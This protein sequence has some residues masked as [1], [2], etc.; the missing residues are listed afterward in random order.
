MNTLRASATAKSRHSANVDNSARSGLLHAQL[1]APGR[2]G[3][4]QPGL[5]GSPNDSDF[6]ALQCAL[7][8]SGGL[9]RGQDLA[10]SLQDRQAGDFTSLARWIVTRR[11]FSFAWHDSFWVPM[12]QLDP[13][14]ASLRPGAQSVVA[15]LVGVLDGWSLALWFVR[16]NSS[17]AE[18]TPLALLDHDLPAVFQAA[19]MERFVVTG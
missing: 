15:E 7:R 2:L 14:D 19:R 13:V 17:L 5:A 16:P 9:A 8:A 12:F 3:L 6:V 4:S 18:R 1:T 11:I 10:H